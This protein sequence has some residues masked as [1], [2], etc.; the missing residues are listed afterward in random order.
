MSISLQE[1]VSCDFEMVSYS[2]QPLVS[3]IDKASQQALV[4]VA[5]FNIPPVILFPSSHGM[6]SERIDKV[7]NIF[8]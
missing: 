2:P 1:D 7:G 8:R 4:S 5:C 6:S 3:L